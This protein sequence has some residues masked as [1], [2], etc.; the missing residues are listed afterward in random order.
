M[1][2]RDVPAWLLALERMAIAAVALAW[3]VRAELLQA[4]AMLTGWALVTAGAAAVS[5]PVAWVFSAGLLLLSL[6]GWKFLYTLFRTG[7]YTLHSVSQE[8]RK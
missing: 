5:S 3:R 1:L 4:S 8:R 7:L 6:C 2:R